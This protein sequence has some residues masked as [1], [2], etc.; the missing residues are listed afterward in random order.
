M[1]S[2]GS[3]TRRGSRCR[4]CSRHQSGRC[5]WHRDQQVDRLAPFVPSPSVHVHVL[6]DDEV[7]AVDDPEHTFGFKPKSKQDNFLRR[8]LRSARVRKVAAVMSTSA[9]PPSG[10]DHPQVVAHC[11]GE[12]LTS[13]RT[14][15]LWHVGASS[16]HALN[17]SAGGTRWGAF[18]LTKRDEGSV[19]RKVR[20]TSRDVPVTRATFERLVHGTPNPYASQTMAELIAACGATSVHQNSDLPCAKLFDP[21]YTHATHPGTSLLYRALGFRFV[22]EGY[23]WHGSDPTTPLQRWQTLLRTRLARGKPCV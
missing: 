10:F 9:Q 12:L 5:R 22:A 1:Q 17:R 18:P 21:Q 23:V 7:A 20:W 6:W 3:P 4:M 14:L 15:E 8:P 11:F 2:C 13:S 19:G 16:A